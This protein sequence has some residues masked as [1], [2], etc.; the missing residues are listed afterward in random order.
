L[1]ISFGKPEWAA[2]AKVYYT[3]ETLGAT[4][5]LHGKV[6]E[7]IHG[8]KLRLEQPDTLFDWVAKEG[9]DRKQFSDTYNSFGVQAKISRLNQLTRDYGVNSVPTLI[10]DGKY[11]TDGSLTGGHDAM[12]R[13][14]SELIAL[15]R[16][17]R[18]GAKK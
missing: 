2:L 12:L 11:R 8:N 5:R 4:A 1:P 16:A 3:L 13:A 6:F 18:G 15:A 7:A 14:A 17:E 10:I 9:L